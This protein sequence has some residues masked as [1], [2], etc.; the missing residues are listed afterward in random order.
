MYI[1]ISIY[2]YIYIYIYAYIYTHTHYMYIEAP[3]PFPW[4]T[5]PWCMYVLLLHVPWS[6][7]LLGW[8]STRTFD[9]VEKSEKS[10]PPPYEAPV[11]F[12][13][14]SLPSCVCVCP[15]TGARAN[16]VLHKEL[17]YPIG[18]PA[19][20]FPLQRLTSRLEEY[21][22][23]KERGE[24]HPPLCIMY[25][26]TFVSLSFAAHHFSTGG[27]LAPVRP[28]WEERGELHP[29]PR[30]HVLMCVCVFFLLQRITF[31]TGGILAPV[32][33]GREMHRQLHGLR[34]NTPQPSSGV[35]PFRSH[36]ER[37]LHICAY[38]Y[39]SFLAH[40]LSALSIMYLCAVVY[41]SFAAHYFSA[42]GILAPVWFGRKERR[43]L[44]IAA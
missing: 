19:R 14:W 8:R 27:I 23:R 28:G 29:P 30:Y 24:F 39:V 31:S 5:Q 40:H 13:R 2:K 37:S 7:S 17:G 36:A 21:A 18:R 41:V 3:A 32:R 33:F 20:Q 16:N 34:V 12:P 22:G 6:A 38:V 44:Q 43:E 15:N 35:N 26:C 25:L 9:L 42:G 11:L 10:F 1:S 4:W